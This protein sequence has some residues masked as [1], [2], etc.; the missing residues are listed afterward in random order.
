[1]SEYIV[2]VVIGGMGEVQSVEIEVISE[3]EEDQPSRK[4]HDLE[5]SSKS[6]CV[7]FHPYLLSL[8]KLKHGIDRSAMTSCLM[9]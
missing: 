9:P 6:L 1:M 4:E 5:I 8:M 2:V 3:E 7:L